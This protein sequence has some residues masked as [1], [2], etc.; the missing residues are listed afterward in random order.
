[1][2]RWAARSSSAGNL[3]DRPGVE[4][5]THSQLPILCARDFVRTKRQGTTVLEDL[6]RQA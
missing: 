2:T 3:R 6:L 4:D 5:S 1:M